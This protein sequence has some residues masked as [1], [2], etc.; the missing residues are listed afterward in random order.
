MRNAKELETFLQGSGI[1]AEEYG[2]LVVM[3]GEEKADHM[4]AQQ[5]PKSPTVGFANPF[6]DG[7]LAVKVAH[8]PE[9]LK[10]AI[11]QVDADGWCYLIYNMIPN[12]NPETGWHVG[13]DF[14]ETF[15]EANARRA[16]SS[17]DSGFRLL[18]FMNKKKEDAPSSDE[19]L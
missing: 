13:E 16:N 14:V 9:A 11:K 1:T 12:G 17:N 10:S 15:Q 6:Q 5:K 7:N 19:A 4:V 8:R 18:P 2:K 3:F